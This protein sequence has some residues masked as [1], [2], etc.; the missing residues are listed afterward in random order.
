EADTKKTSFKKM[1][2]HLKLPIC[3]ADCFLLKA[4]FHLINPVLHPTVADCGSQT[5]ASCQN[6]SSMMSQRGRSFPLL[7][8]ISLWRL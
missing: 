2:L 8:A 6:V 4:F 3:H 1:I 7:S 5:P